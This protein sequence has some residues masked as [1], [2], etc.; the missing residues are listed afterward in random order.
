MGMLHNNTY[1]FVVL[2]STGPSTLCLLIFIVIEH[3]CFVL[4]ALRDFIVHD[5]PPALILL[6]L[7]E[8]FW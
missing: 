7:T 6:R 1:I 2:S 8:L 3:R 4:E 5:V